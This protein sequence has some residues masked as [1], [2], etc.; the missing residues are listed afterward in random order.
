MSKEELKFEDIR[1]VI[2]DLKSNKEPKAKRIN[3]YARDFK[4][5]ALLLEALLKY[6]QF[7]LFPSEFKSFEK[8]SES[9][10][11]NWLY[12]DDTY[13]AYP[14]KIKFNKTYDFHDGS[15][16]ILLEFKNYE[17]HQFA[18]KEWMFAYVKFEKIDSSFEFQPSVIYSSF[19]TEELTKSDLEEIIKFK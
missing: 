15:K 12:I 5:R 3:K 2:V 7:D 13:D 18:K 6:N 16:V 1:S 4:T 14:D 10:L 8:L 17:P 11:A 19:E 9:F